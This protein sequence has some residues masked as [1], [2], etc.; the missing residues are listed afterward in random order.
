MAEPVICCCLNYVSSQPGQLP[1][2]A[3]EKRAALHSDCIPV[4]ST[5]PLSRREAPG[6]GTCHVDFL[7][8]AETRH[9]LAVGAAWVEA[10]GELAL[11]V[12]CPPGGVHGPW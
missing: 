12:L 5:H 11:G 1:L 8:T 3:P 4:P 9:P 6:C 10:Q 7:P 2:E